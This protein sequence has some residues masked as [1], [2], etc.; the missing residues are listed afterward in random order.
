MLPAVTMVEA[1]QA[2]GEF[3]AAGA[4]EAEEPKDF[5][6]PQFERDAARQIS[7][8]DIGRAQNHF[9]ESVVGAGVHG[10][11]R[12]AD[13]LFD[14]RFGGRIGDEPSADGGAVPQHG[15]A[16]GDLVNLIQE[17]AD[18]DDGEPLVAQLADHFEQRLLVLL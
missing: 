10:I 7:T 3:G 16:I 11:D 12:P 6:A 8:M 2:A 15:I 5:T 4:D 17:V 1:E 13:H 18:V 9:A 14:E